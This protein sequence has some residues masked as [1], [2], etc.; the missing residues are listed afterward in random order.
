MIVINVV[1][2]VV[3]IQIARSAD[4]TAVPFD[5]QLMLISLKEKD[6]HSIRIPE[7]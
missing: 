1:D 6:R 4:V 2:V 3:N 5:N 7:Q